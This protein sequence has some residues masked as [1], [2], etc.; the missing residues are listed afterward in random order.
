MVWTDNVLN[1]KLETFEKGILTQIYAP[2]VSKTTAHVYLKPALWF[3][4]IF[5]MDYFV[6]DHVC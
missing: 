3:L 2:M 1:L 4:L 6:D 5:A